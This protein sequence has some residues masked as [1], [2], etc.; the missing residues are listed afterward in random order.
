MLPDTHCAKC[1][2]PILDESPSGDP[3]LRKPCPNCGS[4]SRKFSMTASI[5][6]AVQAMAKATVQTYPQ[7]LLI[8]ASDLIETEQY[9]IS[10]VVS[11][12][13]CEV[14]AERSISSAFKERE[15]EYL[16]EA[17][18]DMLASCNLANERTRKLFHSLVNDD[19]T[20]QPWWQDF[21]TSAARRN[22][23]IHEAM[24]A[25]RVEAISSLDAASQLVGHLEQNRDGEVTLQ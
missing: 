25:S 6:V 10:V 14:A 18:R 22:R 17:V 7:L 2:T 20:E 3:D 5:E 1:G 19:L 12:M 8:A 13:A 16:E 11:H 15:I 4:T 21:K 9:S 24:L 23:V